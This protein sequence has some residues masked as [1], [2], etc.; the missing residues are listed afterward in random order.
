MRGREQLRAFAPVRVCA[1]RVADAQE[2]AALQA[3]LFE[4]AQ[5]DMRRAHLAAQAMQLRRQVADDEA[6]DQF[7]RHAESGFFG[8]EDPDFEWR[9]GDY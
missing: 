6:V 2:A 3:A 8:G 9:V 7:I 1:P 4:S 5:D